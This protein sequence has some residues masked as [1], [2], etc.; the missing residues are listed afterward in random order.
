[1]RHKKDGRRLG[2]P[3]DHRD[4][5]IHNLLNSLVKHER[6]TTT[7]TRA[8][9]LRRVADKVITL[10]KKNT[11]ATLAELTKFIKSEREELI[12][13][14]VEELAPRFA[15]RK[16]GYTRIIKLGSRR[17]D[18]APTAIIEYLSEDVKKEEKK[19][20]AAEVK[21]AAEEKK[22]KAPKKTAEKKKKTEE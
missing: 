5:M 2:R 8:K 6:I 12:K 17:G 13:K 22:A 10:A 18:A 7:L 19:V 20:E 1:M 15:A 3:S 21:P 11:A 9:E 14:L 16:G 4:A